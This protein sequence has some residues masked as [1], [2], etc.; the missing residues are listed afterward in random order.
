MHL[1]SK[2]GILLVAVTA[3]FGLVIVGGLNVHSVFADEDTNPD[4][5]ANG[6][7]AYAASNEGGSV[8]GK[9]I[10]EIAKVACGFHC[11]ND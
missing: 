2:L 3:T 1:K 4:S 6:V 7:A 8:D 9:D 5:N 11:Q 10:R